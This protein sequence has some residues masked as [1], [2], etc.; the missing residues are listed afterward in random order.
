MG[1]TL[2]NTLRLHRA[3]KGEKGVTQFDVS[4]ALNM[5][6]DRYWRIE[7]GHTKPSPEEQAAFADYFGVKVTALFPWAR[8][9]RK[10]GNGEAASVA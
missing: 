5:H 10:A 4:H 7:N 9:S 1:N 2:A 3:G 6:R 8:R